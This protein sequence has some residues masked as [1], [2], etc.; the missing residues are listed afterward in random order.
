MASLVSQPLFGVILHHVL[1]P[2]Q[3]PQEGETVYSNI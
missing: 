1:A 2:D 3:A